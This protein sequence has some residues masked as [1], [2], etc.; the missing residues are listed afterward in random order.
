[1][2][3]LLV[4]LP[5]ILLVVF[6]ALWQKLRRAYRRRLDGEPS[7]GM[8]DDLDQLLAMKAKLTEEEYRR[9]RRAVVQKI[10]DR[11]QDERPVSKEVNLGALEKEWMG[12]K[13]GRASRPNGG[14][15][16]RPQS[17]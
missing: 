8:Q 9:L 10:T 2:E 13:A 16:E 14:P 6:L 1:M 3:Y 4:A 5:I 15:G 12:R 11:S 7:A 17:G